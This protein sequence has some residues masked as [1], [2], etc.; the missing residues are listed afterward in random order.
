[1]SIQHASRVPVAVAVTMLLGGAILGLAAPAAAQPSTARGFVLV[2]GGLQTSTTDFS[3]GAVFTESGGA[4]SD[5][6]SGAAA[7][8]QAAF[9]GTYAVAGGTLFDVGGAIRLWRGLGVGAS[10]ARYALDVATS[11]SAQAPHPF[12]FG[13]ARSISGSLPLTR[14]E[15]A[16]HVHVLGV[17]PAGPSFTVTAFGG[18]TFFTV[19]QSLVTDVR[20][21]HTY[22]YEN[23]AFAEAL[24]TTQATSTIGFHVGADVAY[25]FT[26][27]IG[28]GWLARY[29][30]ATVEFPSAGNGTVTMPVGG[31]HTAG[32]LRVR[33]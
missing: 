25:Y 7:H 33:F 12:F 15:T 9:D 16:V 22:P 11:V 29:S 32:G 6:L 31:L 18:P 24:T 8:E 1:M 4:Y 20:F 10:A 21:T 27:H 26:N 28:V 23:A 2:N 13:R 19:K 17:V 30:T 14:D 3:Q 5:L